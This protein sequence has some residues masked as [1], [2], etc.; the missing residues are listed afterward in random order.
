MLTRVGDR[1]GELRRRFT[2]HR[3]PRY[4][5]WAALRRLMPYLVVGMLIAFGAVF[6]D[7][8]ARRSEDGGRDIL[9]GT[10]PGAVIAGRATIADGDTL[11]IHGRR[12]RLDGIDA[13][14]SAQLC[15]GPRGRYPCG[16]EATR[17]L[18]A[19]VGR[20]TVEC[21]ANGRDRYERILAVCTVNGRDLGAAMVLAGWALAGR[22]DYAAHQREARAAARGVWQ[23]KFQPPADWRREHKN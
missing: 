4:S 9:R 5:A 6:G 7:D 14:E 23:G 17:A 18:G 3:A 13:P 20:E 22:A 1:A 8:V 19:L 2:R 15:D 11:T 10:E 12:I 16:R 21:R